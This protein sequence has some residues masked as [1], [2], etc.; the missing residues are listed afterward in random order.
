MNISKINFY[1]F[2]NNKKNNINFKS[3]PILT[4]V[5]IEHKMDLFCKSPEIKEAL[6]NKFVKLRDCFSEKLYPI[7]LKLNISEWNF[8]INSNKENFEIMSKI[9]D[10]Y[11][12]LW[13]NKDLYNDFLKLKNIEL[14]K[15]EKIQLKNILNNFEDE[16]NTGEELKKLT[17]K[18]NEIA[19]KYNSYIPKINGKETTKAEINKI[20]EKEKNQELR[21]KAYKIYMIFFRYLNM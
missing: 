15:H 12:K 20:L 4:K 3:N 18:E 19:Q 13:Q 11:K 8:Y 21:L 5:K 17:D 2:S 10:E 14:N 7:A 9:Y 16:L 6:M 1:N